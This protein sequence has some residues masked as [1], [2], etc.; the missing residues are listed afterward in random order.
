M[1]ANLT[2]SVPHVVSVQHTASGAS[3]EVYLH[4]ATVTSWKVKDQERLFVSTRAI[5]DESKAIRGG[6]PVVFPI[7]G[8]KE[9]ISL[10][11]H[12]FARI[13]KW[14][15]LGI[16]TESDE[17]ISIRFGLK[18]TQLTHVLR[19]AWPHSFRITYTITLT[20]D[21]LKTVLAV[22][23]EGSDAFEFNTLLHT[24]LA[25][26]ASQAAPS[27]IRWPPARALSRNASSLRSRTRST[28]CIRM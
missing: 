25:V 11:Q 20:A 3:A 16:I 17:E 2:E 9:G 19:S 24:Y 6:I 1:P 21:S 5:L 27:S 8:T 10:P 4:G 26:P 7:F 15:W 28:V 12:G 14:E 23:N 13:T 22:K 18:D